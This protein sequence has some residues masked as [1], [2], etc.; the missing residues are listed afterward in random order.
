MKHIIVFFFL[1]PAA[2]SL[3]A[4]VPMN[5]DS[6]LALL[7]GAKEDSS[8]VQLYINI[9]QQYENSEPETAKYYYRR[10]GELSEKLHFTRGIIAYINNY[11][12]VLNIQGYYDS[13]LQLNLRAIELAGSIHDSLAYAKANFNTG[14][15]YRLMR[16][17]TSAVLYYETG[18]DLL[19]G[20]PDQQMK[21]QI[22]DILQGFYTEMGNL[23]KAI[24]YGEEAVS[25]F[26]KLKNPPMLAS[27]L[28]N[29]GV[30]YSN[31]GEHEKALALFSEAMEISSL[32][33][34]LNM[35]TV[36][37]LN[38]VN[39]HFKLGNY[40]LIRTYLEKAL[41]LARQLESTESEA[42]ALKGLAYYYAHYNNFEA[43]GK[44]ADSALAVAQA[45]DFP[46]VKAEIYLHLANLSYAA[47]DGVL[48]DHYSGLSKEIS[49]SLI[50]ETIIRNT[51]ELETRFDTE[52]QKAKII[53]LTSENRLKELMLQ[54]KR[55]INI[56][57]VSGLIL[58]LVIIYLV[59][60]T[61]NQ[62]QKLQEK[63]IRELEAEKMLAATEAVLKGEEQERSRLARDLHDGL[64]G[65]LS[66][67]KF[68][69]GTMK[70]NMIMTPEN[71]QSFER[72]MDMLDS[73]I[74][75]IR[76]VAHNMMP[77]ALMKF[78][79]DTALRDF[80][81]DIN[82]SGVLM[83]D[84]HSMGLETQVFDQTTNITIY[85]IIQELVN[86]IL[87]HAGASRAIVQ[88]INDGKRLI[89][90]VEDNGKGMDMDQMEGGAGI[91][92]NNIRNRVDFLKG[93]L[94]ITSVPD[95]GTSVQIII[96]L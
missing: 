83:I 16:D 6:L 55:I 62:K 86:N 96:N 64:G 63:K 82:N 43:S 36:Q 51:I 23:T 89:V 49:D 46:K 27:S 15:S 1:I 87:K 72:A 44:Y 48:G 77:E 3:P 61:L 5:R 95:E 17:Y 35:E 34:D 8:K 75:E 68:S 71:M 38:M 20:Y 94:D 76:R 29:L 2:I 70:S 33:G 84:Y 88:L 30:V 21:A 92:W 4:Q 52:R 93:E 10:A 58:L 56:V 14:T 73:S 85:R 32:N 91:G 22:L 40:A 65:L 12:Y 37:Y 80:C 25:I 39:E 13:S 57:L 53:H 19:L 81:S 67:I 28:T 7:P 9:G 41:K 11:T 54:R 26:R 45:F 24:E 90:T 50:N 47:H 69:F 79:L 42:I 74:V 18:K 59:Y 78:G 60:R 66:G 31:Q